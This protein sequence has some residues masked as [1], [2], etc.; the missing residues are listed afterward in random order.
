MLETMFYSCFL[1]GEEEVS[2]E[3]TDVTLDNGISGTL[4]LM[5]KSVFS[6][7]VRC[8]ARQIMHFFPQVIT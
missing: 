1:E 2:L 4:P 3:V 8:W 5:I 6:T 7:T